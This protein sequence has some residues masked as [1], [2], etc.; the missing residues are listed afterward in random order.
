MA[1][2]I[3]KQPVSIVA[4]VGDTIKMRVE[5]TGVTNFQ[6]QNSP[7][8]KTWSNSGLPG[9]NTATLSVS[10]TTYRYDY[11]WRC[12][13]TDSSGNVVYTDAVMIRNPAN[14][15]GFVE[16]STLAAIADAIRAKT[17][18]TDTML[19]S[20]M[21]GHIDTITRGGVIRTG[22]IQASGNSFTL[23]VDLPERE[24]YV[25]MMLLSSVAS[26]YKTSTHI[27][28]ACIYRNGDDIASYIDEFSSNEG[29]TKQYKSSNYQ[30][31][32]SINH[33][34]GVVT[35]GIGEDVKININNTYEWI[36][37]AWEGDA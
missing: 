5:A 7:D 17:K 32:P 25:F 31:Q 24:N 18:S 13:L 34:S 11:L 10:V 37:C 12:E 22:T 15:V 28:G 9:C 36:Y 2:T 16:Y 21:P 4:V 8:G 20:E 33:E 27:V 6:W 19:P 26:S 14:S 3:T 1:I 35:L 30:T 29:G 23:G